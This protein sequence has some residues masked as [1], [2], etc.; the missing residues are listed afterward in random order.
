MADVLLLAMDLRE[1]FVIRNALSE[2]IRHTDLSDEEINAAWSVLKEMTTE[3]K[4]RD[5]PTDPPKGDQGKAPNTG[6]STQ[7][8]SD[9]KATADGRP[10]DPNRPHA[11]K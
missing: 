11:D 6:S 2:Y 10:V 8:K 5:M 9:N 4:G 3:V 1:A 7:A